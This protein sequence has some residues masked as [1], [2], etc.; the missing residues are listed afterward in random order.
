M[1]RAYTHAGQAAVTGFWQV[2]GRQ[3]TTYEERVLMDMFYIAHWSIWLDLF[4]IAKT[5]WSVIRAEGAY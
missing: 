4:I 5:F 3:N 2:M 1:S